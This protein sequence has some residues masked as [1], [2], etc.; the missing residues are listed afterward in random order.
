VSPGSPEDAAA[1]PLVGRRW[2]LKGRVQGVGFR[3]Y[4]LNY[5][6]ALGVRGWIRN[7]ADGA[8][9]VVALASASTIDALDTLLAKGPPGAMVLEVL[10]TDVQHEIVDGKSFSIRH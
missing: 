9:E 10:R 7:T 6:Q 8:V 4:V 3:W 1:R 2:V 5:A